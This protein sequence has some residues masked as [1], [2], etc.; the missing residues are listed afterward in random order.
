MPATI[1]VAP[2]T[3]P[4]VTTHGFT[5]NNLTIDSLWGGGASPGTV[6]VSFNLYNLDPNTEV[7]LHNLWLMVN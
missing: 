6:L 3:V 4:V 7:T 2:V 5:G 1:Q